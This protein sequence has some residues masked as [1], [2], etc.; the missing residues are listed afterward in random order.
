MGVA[1]AA[2]PPPGGRAMDGGSQVSAHRTTWDTSAISTTRCVAA[3]TMAITLIA[4]RGRGHRGVV[5]RRHLDIVDVHH[6]SWYRNFL[7]MMVQH[8]ACSIRVAALG[9]RVL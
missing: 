4:A 6:A 1:V 9:L 2:T 5:D 3:K 7:C 8:F